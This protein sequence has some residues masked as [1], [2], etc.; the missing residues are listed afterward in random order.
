M[1]LDPAS[2][3]SAPEGSASQDGAG[4][5][6]MPSPR[7]KASKS[8]AGKGKKTQGPVVSSK[9]MDAAMDRLAV[10]LEE[11]EK[12]L[13]PSKPGDPT[14]VRSSYVLWARRTCKAIEDVLVKAKAR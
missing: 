2:H 10:V 4:D 9:E 14:Y 13:A 6:V 12:M 7:K 8:V 3:S 11:G 1:T 5:Q